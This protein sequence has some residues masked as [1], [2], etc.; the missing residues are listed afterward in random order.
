MRSL[1]PQL[2]GLLAL[3]VSPGSA[4][5]QVVG[6]FEGRTTTQGSGYYVNARPGEAT[7]R[8]YVW[9]GVREPGVY[10]VGEGF[11][12][13]SVLSLAGLPVQDAGNP[14]DPEVFVSVYRSGGAGEP[15]Y[16]APLGAFAA[17]LAS[18][19][20][21]R[22]GDVVA[23]GVEPAAR[24][25]V[26]GAVGAPGLYPVGPEF[27]AQAVLSL[28]GGPLLPALQENTEREVTVRYLRQSGELFRGDLDAFTR[29]DLPD[30]V[31]G[32]V[33]EVEIRERRGFSFRDVLSIAGAV[34][35]IASA[36][37]IVITQLSSSSN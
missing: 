23:V 20:V 12:L 17:D 10:E 37:V 1:M 24:V 25:N 28:A 13:L 9:G 4:E 14:A 16:R 2:V 27:D 31:D 18:H 19:P 29:A 30:P 7:T 11:D 36:V 35:G 3:W 8:V 33:I 26:W 22:E 32:D 15:V 34:A 5:A 21:L 6:R